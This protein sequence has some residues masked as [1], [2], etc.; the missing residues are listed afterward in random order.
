[1]VMFGELG[2]SRADHSFETNTM[3]MDPVLCA[4]T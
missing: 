3:M 4:A 2:L 1:M